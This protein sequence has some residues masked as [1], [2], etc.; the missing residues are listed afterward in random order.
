V[1]GL[2]R[3]THQE[4]LVATPYFRLLHQPAADRVAVEIMRVEMAD[5]AGGLAAVGLEER[6]RLA[7]QER[8][9]KATLV[10]IQQMSQTM[11]QV[12]AAV[13]EQ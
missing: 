6:Q 3:Q 2:V 1:A 12:V 11:A 10:V 13:R 8:L 9:I 4:L 7:V 5:R